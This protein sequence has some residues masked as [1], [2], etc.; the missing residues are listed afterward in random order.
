MIHRHCLDHRHPAVHR[1]APIAAAEVAHEAQ[2]AH[3]DLAADAGP[4]ELAGVPERPVP[5]VH[6]ALLAERAAHPLGPSLGLAW[7]H[8]EGAD[9][10]MDP[11]VKGQ[12]GR[13]DRGARQQRPKAGAWRSP[14]APHAIAP[15]SA[16][17]GCKR[18]T[19]SARAMTKPSKKTSRSARS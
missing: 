16:W 7:A 9:E 18:N 8:P 17:G 3:H 12:G 2:V 19:W 6:Q 13:H 15:A 11:C 5:Q 1:D 14:I 10:G 4:A